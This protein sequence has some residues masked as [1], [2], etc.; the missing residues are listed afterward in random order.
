MP[1]SWWTS[2]STAFGLIVM[3]GE[4]PNGKRVVART[5]ERT[6]GPISS[7]REDI[8]GRGSVSFY[9]VFVIDLAS[10]ACPDCGVYAISE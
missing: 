6:P 10:P 9:T 5:G 8:D 7:R 2:V 1:C 3:S 4:R